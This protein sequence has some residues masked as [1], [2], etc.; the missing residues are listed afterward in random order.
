MNSQPKTTAHSV[1]NAK[2]PMKMKLRFHVY[3]DAR[4]TTRTC[5]RSAWARRYGP[6]SNPVSPDPANAVKA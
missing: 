5:Y 1:A 6:R 4:P 3:P 2:L